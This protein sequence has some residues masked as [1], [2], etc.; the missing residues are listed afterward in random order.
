MEGARARGQARAQHDR[1][2]AY[3]ARIQ[4]AGGVSAQDVTRRALQWKERGLRPEKKCSMRVIWQAPSATH[5]LQLLSKLHFAFTYHMGAA[6]RG[7]RQFRLY[8]RHSAL[9]VQAQADAQ[10]QVRA[11]VQLQAQADVQLQQFDR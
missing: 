5:I 7:R 10:L 4:M 9:Q 6:K 11:D 2:A 1:D 8:D 3:I